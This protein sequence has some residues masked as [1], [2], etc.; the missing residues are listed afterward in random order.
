[1]ISCSNM[2]SAILLDVTAVVYTRS[3]GTYLHLEALRGDEP[4]SNGKRASATASGVMVIMATTAWEP[5]DDKGFER[6]QR[7]WVLID[8]SRRVLRLSKVMVMERSSRA[9]L[10]KMGNDFH[11][12]YRIVAPDQGISQVTG[13]LRR[14]LWSCLL[15]QTA[16]TSLR[17]FKMPGDWKRLLVHRDGHQDRSGNC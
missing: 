16:H 3:S 9:R 7:V 11:T 5:A 13:L 6:G 14:R 15:H 10:T 17:H 2:I 12:T 1:M 4:C 8:D